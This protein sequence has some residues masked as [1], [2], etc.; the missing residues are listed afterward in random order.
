M[1]EY[2][3]PSFKFKKIRMQVIKLKY[4]Y[5]FFILFFISCEEK[6]NE[7]YVISN[8]EGNYEKRLERKYVDSLKLVNQFQINGYADIMRVV[9]SNIYFLEYQNNKLLKYDGSGNYLG[10]FLKGKGDGP[11]ELVQPLSMG[12]D[13]NT[14]YVFDRGLLTLK[15]FQQN[16]KQVEYQNSIKLEKPYT[17]GNHLNDDLF[18]FTILNSDNVL[19]FDLFNFSDKETRAIDTL[20]QVFK[21]SSNGDFLYDGIVKSDNDAFYY[22]MYSNSSFIK[23]TKDKVLYI[24]KLI[25]EVPGPKVIKEGNSTFLSKGIKA[26]FDYTVH[27]KKIFVLSG[28]YSSKIDNKSLSVDIYNAENGEYLK[29]MLIPKIKDYP[30]L[31]PQHID[32]VN[33]KLLV[34]YEESFVSIYEL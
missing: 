14:L 12:F 33:D 26:V 10:S 23:F 13:E 32:F 15:S 34:L 27:D 29:S 22:F 4:V 30:A 5:I 17:Q 25:H 1:G 21:P 16:Q 20:S 9:H 24:S 2:N 28:I 19:E 31:F 18:L 8:Y 11:E 3:S 7:N 6:Q